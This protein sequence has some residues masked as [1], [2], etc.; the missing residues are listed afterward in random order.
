MDED[1]REILMKCW[2]IML[3]LDE[4]WHQTCSV[5]S[6]ENQHIILPLEPS[7]LGR[8]GS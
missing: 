3:I 4:G 7:S 5:P 8:L 6:R 1:G 2:L